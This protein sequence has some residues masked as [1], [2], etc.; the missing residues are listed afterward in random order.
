MQSATLMNTITIWI[1]SIKKWSASLFS[2][3]DHVM[4]ATDFKWKCQNFWPRWCSVFCSLCV[5]S[6]AEGVHHSV[7]AAAPAP[8]FLPSSPFHMETHILLW[9][10]SLLCNTV[11]EGCSPYTVIIYTSISG[12]LFFRAAAESSEWKAGRH[13]TKCPFKNKSWGKVAARRHLEVNGGINQAADGGCR[14]A[15]TQ[16]QRHL[17]ISEP[18][19]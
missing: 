8:T 19:L 14:L 6:T 5:R 15:A 3:V 1:S 4:I 7:A 10:K 11:T 18:D 16:W 2:R 12:M 17:E 9:L 13:G